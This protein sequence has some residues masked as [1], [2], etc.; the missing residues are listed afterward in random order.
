M[1]D[2]DHLCFAMDFTAKANDRDET[3]IHMFVSQSLEKQFDTF[4]EFIPYSK[5]M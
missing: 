4:L 2:S 3:K 1:S 5:A